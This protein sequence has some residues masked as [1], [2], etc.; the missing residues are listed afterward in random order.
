MQQRRSA[1]SAVLGILIVLAAHGAVAPAA[2]IGQAVADTGLALS[3]RG[4]P[5]LV[6][7]DEGAIEVTVSLDEPADLRLR[8]ADFDGR[9]V[10][11][12]FDGRRPAGTLK[13]TWRGRGEGGI[14]P[15]GPYRIVAAASPLDAPTGAPALR[16]EAWITLAERALYHKAPGLITVALDPGHGGSLDGAVAPDGTREADLNLDIALRLARMLEGSGVNVALTRDSDRDVNDPPA[17]LTGDDVID[18]TD[19][20]AARTDVANLARADLFISVHNNIAVNESVGG[21]GTFFFDE[22]TFGDR[23]KRIARIVQAEMLAAQRAVRT[24]DWQPYERGP[25]IYPYYVL[26][27]YDPPRLLRPTQMPGVLS[28][29]LF[30]SNPRELGLLKQP[31]MRQAMAVAYYDAIARYLA[32]R[33]SHVGYR[34]LAGPAEAVAGEVASFE[35]E[36]RNQGSEPLRGWELVAAALPAPSR[37]IGRPRAR[38][39]LG[40]SRIPRLEPGETAMLSIDVEAPAPGQDWMLLF[41]ARDRNGR[42]A[43]L[44]GSPVLQTPFTTTDPPAL[45]DTAGPSPGPSSSAERP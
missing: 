34:L 24:G 14:V 13:R 32:R 1:V 8:V 25:L 36:V 15:E 44:D 30:L 19:E 26:R 28:E 5:L 43:A 23:S 2:T 22:R 39:V 6:A 38:A 17:D 33:G 20:L 12:L 3:V 41:D 10:Q 42:R 9:T 37:Y 27:D 7:D 40:K 4:S 18:E 21:P 35:V 16:A 29:G 31:R 11:E 45:A